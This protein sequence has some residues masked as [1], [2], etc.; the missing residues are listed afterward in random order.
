MSSVPPSRPL[1]RRL[2]RRTIDL[3]VVAFLAVVGLSI[4]SQLIDWWRTD[5]NEVA[6]DLSDLTGLDFDWHRTPIMLRFGDAS[7]SLERIPFHGRR[8]QLEE[9]LVHIAQAIVTNTEIGASPPEAAERDWLTALQGAAPVFWDSTRGNVYR[10]DEPLPSFV[11]TRFVDASVKGPA[12]EGE[13]GS[14]R[15]VGWGLAFP[16]GADHWTIYVFHPDSAKSSQTESRP[17][18][19]LPQGASNITNLSGS[20]GCQWRVIQGRGELAG[21]VQHFDRQFGAEHQIARA[22]QAQTASLKYRR[23]QLLTDVH[24]RREPDGRLTGVL[25]SA[26]E[27]EKQ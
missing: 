12:Q 21:W 14:Q 20:D 1:G 22:I 17:E 3:L 16:S 10:R 23:G 9:E 6:P 4:G 24:I 19:E 5:A 27:R 11:A 18:I 25:W 15:I 26:K 7:T 2:L 13:V 8:R